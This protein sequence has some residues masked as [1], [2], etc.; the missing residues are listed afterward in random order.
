MKEDKSNTFGQ[1]IRY[2]IVGVTA[3]LALYLSY[4]LLT[5]AGVGHKTAMTGLYILGTI[6]TFIANKAWTFKH[7]GSGVSSFMRYIIAYFSGYMTNFLGLYFL[8]DILLYRHEI[9][10]LIM[11][12]VVAIQL[13]MLQRLWVFKS[14]IT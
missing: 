5:Y 2:G 10:Q 7:R 3:N 12:F 8:V 4:L 1:L 9:V 14:N 6:I 11:L 13:F